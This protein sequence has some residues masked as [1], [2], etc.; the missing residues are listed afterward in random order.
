MKKLFSSVLFLGVMLFTLPAFAQFEG[1]VSMKVYGEDENGNPETSEFSLYTTKDRIALK[2]D[3]PYSFMD[4]SYDA[5]GILIRNDKEDF[6]VMMGQDEA[7]QFTKEEVEGLFQMLTMMGDDEEMEVESDINADFIYTNKTKTILGYECT[8][9]LVR[10]TENGNSLSIWLTAGIDIN[11]GM[12]A[13]PWKNVP[14]NM[15]KSANRATQE[16][17]SKN[18]P[19]QIEATEKGETQTIFEV[20]S[21]QKSSIARAMVEVPAGVSLV[22]LGEIIFS[23]MMKN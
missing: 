15:Q 10:D 21:V 4:G 8:E 2:G 12:L 20:T 5:S 14:T 11:W 22:G 7:L 1:Q 16:F 18:F 13:E 9:L 17:K 3:K 19:M 6:V 23:M